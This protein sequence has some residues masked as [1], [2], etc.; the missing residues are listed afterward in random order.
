MVKHTSIPIRQIE[1]TPRE[2]SQLGN[3]TIRDLTELLA[4]NSL[5]QN[6]HRHDFFYILLITKGSGKHEIDFV[7]YQIDRQSLFIMRPGQVHEIS[8]DAGSEGYLMQ[9]GTDF[10]ADD[11]LSRRLLQRAGNCNHHILSD[12]HFKKVDYPLDQLLREYNQKQLSYRD[13]IK[14]YLNLFLIEIQRQCAECDTLIP[15]NASY[16]HEKLEKFM[17]LVQQN[18]GTVK[19]PSDYAE[20]IHLTPSQ[21]NAL[22]KKLLSKTAS[23]VIVDQILLEAKRLLLATPAQV[24]TIAYQL[25]YEDAS[26]FIRFFKKHIGVSPEI[27]RQNSK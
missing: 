14:S 2:L 3:F 10:F 20:M 1:K 12:E 26:Y 24:N 25:G 16:A 6:L 5:T 4:G 23:E 8:L 22:T 13:A 21:L 9:I 11:Q 27:F 19:K 7:P 17:G 18:I 15:A